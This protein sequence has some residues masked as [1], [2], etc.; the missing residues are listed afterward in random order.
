[1]VLYFFFFHLLWAILGY[2]QKT[3]LVKFFLQNSYI[4]IAIILYTHIV[5]K[6]LIL[7]FGQIL[8]KDHINLITKGNQ[9]FFL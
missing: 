8:A 9:N 2:L 1:M 5:S 4:L 3:N 7:N 6:F